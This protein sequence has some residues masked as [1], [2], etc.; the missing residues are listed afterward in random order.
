MICDMATVWSMMKALFE[1][2]AMANVG[3]VEAR[4]PYWRNIALVV[5][6]TGGHWFSIRHLQYLMPN[7]RNACRLWGW[8]NGT[9]I[10]IEEVCLTDSTR[11]YPFRDIRGTKGI[12]LVTATHRNYQFRLWIL[13][14]PGRRLI[15]RRGQCSNLARSSDSWR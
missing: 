15:W 6:R 2:R 8:M 10:T 14:R 4:R 12:L 11:W 1:K 3:S 13:Q 5:I 7:D 9:S